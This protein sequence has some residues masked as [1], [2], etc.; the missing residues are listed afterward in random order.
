MGFSI[1]PFVIILDKANYKSW[2]KGIITHLRWIKILPYLYGLILESETPRR[3]SIWGNIIDHV[4]GVIGSH[5]DTYTM[6][7]IADIE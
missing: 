7:V 4:L 1:H 3:K 2:K 6:L 5:V